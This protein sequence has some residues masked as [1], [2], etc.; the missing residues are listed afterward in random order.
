MQASPLRFCHDWADTMICRRA[1]VSSA[2][3]PGV[4]GMGTLAST[5]RRSQRR[6]LG[7]R[8]ARNPF[9]MADDAECRVNM[10]GLLA[11]TRASSPYPRNINLT[12]E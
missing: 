1:N 12:G 7:A 5:K 9:E 2:S 10:P 4:A 3:C 11:D 6:G 8:V